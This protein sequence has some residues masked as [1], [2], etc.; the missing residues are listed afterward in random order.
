MGDGVLERME[1][2]SVLLK[3]SQLVSA[4]LDGKRRKMT[5]EIDH[6]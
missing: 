4:L 3:C 2:I 5:L 6:A 1:K